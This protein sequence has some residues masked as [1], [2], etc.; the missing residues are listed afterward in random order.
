MVAAILAALF[1]S[2]CTIYG[3]KKNKGWNATGGEALQ[4]QFWEEVKDKNLDELRKHIAVS[5]VWQTPEGVLD[6]DATLERFR[7][8]EVKDYVL[9]DFK[10]TPNGHDIVVT[11]TA[12]FKGASGG[13]ELEPIQW[14][15]MTV[16]QKAEKGWIAIAHAQVR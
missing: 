8:T 13:R 12:M 15:M 1:L 14:K 4:R 3:G 10:V 2:G 9:G 5:W 11:Y 7:N 16:W 6:R